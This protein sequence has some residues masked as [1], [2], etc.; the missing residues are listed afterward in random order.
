MDWIPYPHNFGKV[1][2]KTS[3]FDN[4]HSLVKIGKRAYKK[5]EIG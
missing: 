3:F 5:D 2:F 1:A 4:G